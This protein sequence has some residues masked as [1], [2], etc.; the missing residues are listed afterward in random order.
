MLSLLSFLLHDRLLILPSPGFQNYASTQPL[1]MKTEVKKYFSVGT[2]DGEAK[3]VP[4]FF[5]EDSVRKLKAGFSLTSPHSQSLLADTML[6]FPP[7]QTLGLEPSIKLLGFKPRDGNL[8]FE[9][10]IKHGYFLAPNE[11]TYSG[12][13]RTFAALLKSMIKKDVVGLARL[14]ARKTG[15]IQL[16][17]LVPQ[18][19]RRVEIETVCPRPSS[20]TRVHSSHRRKRLLMGFRSLHPVFTSSS[21]RS[22]TTFGKSVSNRQPLSSLKTLVGCP[23]HMTLHHAY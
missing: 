17:L 10:T 1:D 15:K 7:M 8:R 23:L 19:R 11:V 2:T 9:E 6:S 21:C 5:D 13:T 22:K 18:V 4:I 3:P 14:I 12:S 20:H 16:V